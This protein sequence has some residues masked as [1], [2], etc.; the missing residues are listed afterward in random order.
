MNNNQKQIITYR[1]DWIPLQNVNQRLLCISQCPG[2][3]ESVKKEQKISDDLGVLKENSIQTIVS[4]LSLEELE[5]LGLSSLFAK[6]KRFGFEHIHFSI[7]DRSIPRNKVEFEK[8]I[9]YLIEKIS[10]GHIVF[11]HCNAGLGRSGLLAALICKS[12]NV[13][14]DPIE[15]VRKFRKGSVETIEQEN[16]IKSLFN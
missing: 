6:I 16:M 4:L 2:K 10:A 14:L 9:S 1:L 13:S 11:I 7:K 5:Q 12:M 15:Y 8:L 3:T